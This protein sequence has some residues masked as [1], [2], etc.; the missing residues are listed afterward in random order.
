MPV[1]PVNCDTQGAERTILLS[2]VLSHLNSR[3]RRDERECKG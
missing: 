1:Q 2:M 3:E